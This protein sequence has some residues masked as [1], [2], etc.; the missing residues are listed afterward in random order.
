MEHMSSCKRSIYPCLAPFLRY[1]KILVENR[2][3]N[4]P[5]LYLAFPLG[6][7][8]LEFRR[9]FW[10]QKTRGS[11]PSYGVVCV[12]LGLAVFVELRL[13]I[14]R[15]TDRPTHD[16]SVYRASIASYGKNCIYIFFFSF[17]FQSTV[18]MHESQLKQVLW[19]IHPT[20]GRFRSY[21]NPRALT[22]R[23]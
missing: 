9:D 12:I 16:G 22:E 6:V 11:G 21:E 5:H 15:R 20:L 17:R 1:N 8:P 2:C 3:F 18:R 23:D 7:I 4:L 10:H 19:Q 13:V 14:D